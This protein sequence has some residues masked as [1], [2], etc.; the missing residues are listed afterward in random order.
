[1]IVT[2]V[3]QL[4]YNTEIGLSVGLG[5]SLLV[6]VYDVVFDSNQ[7]L[8]A[9]TIDIYP[10]IPVIIISDSNNTNNN[11]NN[12]NTSANNRH[13]NGNISTNNANSNG[14]KGNNS[15]GAYN[16]T[17]NNST[18]NNTTNNNVSR[19]ITK[20][21][22]QE[23]HFTFLNSGRIQD[24]LMQLTYIEVIPT[25]TTTALT[26][27]SPSLTTAVA[28]GVGAGAVGGHT[29]RNDVIFTNITRTL[30]RYL[31][32]GRLLQPV[33]ALPYALVIDISSVRTIDLT[34]IM[35]LEEVRLIKI[36]TCYI[37]IYFLYTYYSTLYSYMTL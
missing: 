14:I 21:T 32:K 6:F 34:A 27:T 35:V 12:C 31:R 7:T 11:N 1:M 23:T 33:E 24:F 25:A 5:L 3:L 2:F 19:S 28:A 10:T 8:H 17:Y 9:E 22:F 18:N 4:V 36:Y 16:N 20:V 15:N 37:L 29:R 26:T 13:S 30:D